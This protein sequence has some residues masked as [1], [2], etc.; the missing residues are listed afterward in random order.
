MTIFFFFEFAIKIIGFGTKVYFRDSFNKLD[1]FVVAFSLVDI[2][3]VFVINF[4]LESIIKALRAFRLIKVFKLAK[5]FD[6]FRNLLSTI[7]KTIDDMK[8]FLIVIFLFIYVYAVLGI[9]AFAY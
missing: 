4:K 6:A 7:G 9:Q 1:T 3:I 8:A 2:M 5:S